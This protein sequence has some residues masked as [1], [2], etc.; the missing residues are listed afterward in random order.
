MNECNYQ[1]TNE[2]MKQVNEFKKK[3]E[4]DVWTLRKNN[5]YNR[6]ANW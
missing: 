2:R 1:F 6:K 3:Y 5:T 4:E